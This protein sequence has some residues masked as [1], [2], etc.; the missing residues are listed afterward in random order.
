MEMTPV[1]F[2]VTVEVMGV[3]FAIFFAAEAQIPGLTQT[4]RRKLHKDPNKRIRGKGGI[5]DSLLHCHALSSWKQRFLSHS[6]LSTP[7]P[8]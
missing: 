8:R 3:V 5:L 2:T 7:V 6:A 1:F 4:H